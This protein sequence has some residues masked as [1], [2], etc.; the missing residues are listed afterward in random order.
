VLI[1]VDPGACS[2]APATSIAAGVVATCTIVK[3]LVSL[4]ARLTAF[5]QIEL[6]QSAGEHRPI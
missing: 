5:A 2:G 3:S 1:P 4:T 6:R